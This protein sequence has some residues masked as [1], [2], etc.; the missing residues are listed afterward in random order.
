MKVHEL[1]KELR[2]FPPNSEVKFCS[3]PE[4]ELVLLSVYRDDNDAAETA[5]FDLELL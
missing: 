4:D 2:T 1:I 5:W 3:S